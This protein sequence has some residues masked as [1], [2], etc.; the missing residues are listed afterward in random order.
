MVRGTTY[1]KSV[2]GAR[3]TGAT[4]QDPHVVLLA[5]LVFLPLLALF[6]GL[7]LTVIL[8]DLSLPMIVL[9][10]VGAFASV[11][12][13]IGWVGYILTRAKRQSESGPKAD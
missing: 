8:A 13:A 9:C 10:F 2:G 11:G 1:G 4:T 12:L 7:I 6:F 3:E 5:A